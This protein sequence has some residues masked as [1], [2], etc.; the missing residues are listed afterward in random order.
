ME[1]ILHIGLHKTGTTSIQTFFQR[2]IAV[3]Q[4][5]GLDFYQ[6][7]VFPENHVELHAASMRP[8]RES[9]YKNRT[10]VKVDAGYIDQVRQHVSRFVAGS[11]AQRIIFSSEGLSLLRYPDELETL[12]SLFPPGAWQVLVYLRRPAD[13]LRSYAAQ[14]K[15]DPGTLPLDI[16]KDSFA[17]TEPDS[18]LA[19]YPA[20]LL[21]FEQVFG[22]TNV[23]AVDYDNALA[24][25]GNVIPSF[26]QAVSL[27]DCFRS[28]DWENCFYNRS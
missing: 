19:D 7:M 2:N 8:E 3:L 5:N 6:G 16:E 9:G 27:Q 21:P 14:L 25:D 13:Y 1:Y 28:K 24:K 20:R 18:W 11:H 23:R 17:Y 10:G 26:M 4:A 22:K 12:K 15:K